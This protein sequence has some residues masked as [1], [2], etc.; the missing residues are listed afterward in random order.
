ILNSGLVRNHH[1]IASAA[2]IFM[3]SAIM[4]SPFILIYDSSWLLETEG[5]L[6]AMH[7]GVLATGLAYYLFAIGLKNV[8]S[9]TAV[10]LSLAE[11]FPAS[12]LG[13]FLVGE[14]LDGCSCKGLFIMFMSIV[15]ILLRLGRDM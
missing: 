3:T 6:A 1:P 5:F 14:I 10:T 8:K 4:L 12:L 15:L 7:I 2:V 13:V 11:P 9:S